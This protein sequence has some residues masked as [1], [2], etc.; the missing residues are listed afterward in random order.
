VC[1]KIEMFAFPKL[2]YKLIFNQKAQSIHY[3]SQI[4]KCQ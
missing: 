2:W 3:F 4:T 1:N